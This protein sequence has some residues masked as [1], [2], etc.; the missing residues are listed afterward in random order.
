MTPPIKGAVE[1][2]IHPRVQG[3]QLHIVTAH[4]KVTESQTS[5][6]I[7]KYFS[8]GFHGVHFLHENQ[9]KIGEKGDVC[10]GL[11]A[12]FLIEDAL[13]NALH[14]SM[15][16]THVFLFDTPWNQTDD[17]PK[18]VTRVFGWDATG[19]LAR[20]KPGHKRRCRSANRR[21]RFQKRK[22]FHPFTGSRIDPNGGRNRRHLRQGP[23][24]WRGLCPG[25]YI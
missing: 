1:A 16:T 19:G 11:Q 10:T 4:D 9:K 6:L 12:D 7:K 22:G 5:H 20:R 15:T 3:V 21:D 18:N 14:P 8:P 23:R 24:N 2:I 25:K 17:L 13:H